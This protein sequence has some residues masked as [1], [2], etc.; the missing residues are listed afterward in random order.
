MAWRHP[1]SCRRPATGAD[2]HGWRV[3]SRDRR[4]QAYHAPEPRGL[5]IGLV[6]A[7]R[8]AAE[9]IR[10][11]KRMGPGGSR[12]LQIRRRRGSA[13]TGGFDSHTLPPT[14]LP[15]PQREAPPLWETPHAATGTDTSAPGDFARRDRG[16]SNAAHLTEITLNPLFRGRAGDIRLR[17]SGYRPVSPQSRFASG[18]QN[19][20][21]R[22]LRV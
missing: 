11:R 1:L 18:G 22:E 21:K 2:Q 19:C 4:A 16:S 6:S 9:I 13:G 15:L 14:L 3:P 12:G 7:R 5:E 10:R 20:S 17:E 8:P